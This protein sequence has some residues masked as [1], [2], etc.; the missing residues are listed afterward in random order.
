MRLA[1]YRRLDVDARGGARDAPRVHLTDLLVSVAV[2]G[3]VLAAIF[4]LLTAG[5]QAYA[6]GSGRVEAQQSARV[7]LQRMAREIRTAGRGGGTAFPAISVAEPERIVLH[8]DTNGDGAISRRGETITWRLAGTILRRDA[9]GGA[10]PVING[11]AALRLTY[12]DASGQQTASPDAVRSVLISLTARPEYAT[13]VATADVA[14]TV[15][16]R[17]RLRNR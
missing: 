8:V 13:P 4:G 12:L 7:A 11:V 3:L 6:I 17:V 16:T 5:Q 14:T 15:S 1:P 2:T 9:G 10:Q